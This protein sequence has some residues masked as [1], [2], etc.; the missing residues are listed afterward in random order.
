MEAKLEDLKQKVSDELC[1]L[2]EENAELRKEL[3]SS[4]EKFHK[5]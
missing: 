4:T 5:A 1:G 3:E 2:R